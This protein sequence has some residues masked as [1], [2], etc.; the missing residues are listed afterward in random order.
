MS[1]EEREMFDELIQW[2]EAAAHMHCP[3]CGQGREGCATIHWL[4]C[5]L[6][7]SIKQAKEM[8]GYGD[9]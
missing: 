7:L 8:V 3:G 1:K 5:G 2:C 9:E 6:M 4:G